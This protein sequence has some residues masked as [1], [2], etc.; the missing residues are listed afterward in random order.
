MKAWMVGDGE[1][2]KIVD[3]KDIDVP[4]RRPAHMVPVRFCD[5][6]EGG[7][8]ERGQKKVCGLDRSWGP[9][10]QAWARPGGAAIPKSVAK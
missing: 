4:F 6:D 7:R 3:V 10:G 9:R 5:D 2:C 1:E 8:G